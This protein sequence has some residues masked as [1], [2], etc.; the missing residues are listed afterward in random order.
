[1]IVECCSQEKT[2][3]SFYGLLGERFCRLNKVWE[4][5]FSDGF[6]ET[7]KTI[8]RFETN[9]L[10]NIA[11]FYGHLLA[12]DAIDWNV[13]SLIS[14][15]EQ[16]TTSS[17]RIFLKILL[18]DLVSSLGLK[19]LMERFN[20]ETMIISVQTEEGLVNRNAFEGM[21]PKDHPKNTRFAINYYTSIGLGSLTGIIT[22]FYA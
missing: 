19:K 21:F 9:R 15:T 7:Y 20:D 16:D 11:K 6:E 5:A 13:F 18:Q 4:S 14:L 8:H 22:L 2:F 1:M 10:R 17:S 12:A 3:V